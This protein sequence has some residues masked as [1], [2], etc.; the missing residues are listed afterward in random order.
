MFLRSKKDF[1]RSFGN[2][3]VYSM[4]K[5]IKVTI[6][7]LMSST[8]NAKF[9]IGVFDTPCEELK[10]KITSCKEH[11]ISNKNALS[12]S[13]QKRKD[14]VFSKRGALV[15]ATIMDRKATKCYEKHK[16]KPELYRPGKFKS[17]FF[18]DKL[19]CKNNL[20]NVKVVKPNFYCDTPG[21]ATIFSCYI[22]SLGR[23]KGFEYTVLKIK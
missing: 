16:M 14:I 23:Q 3:K 6:L 10:L 8:T 17:K 2:I 15:T 4:N 18:I 12:T 5:Y 11:I 21:T 22:S 19:S 1:Q 7:L 20:L 13:L 9:A